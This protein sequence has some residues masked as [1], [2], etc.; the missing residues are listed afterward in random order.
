MVMLSP[1]I[2]PH[3]HEVVRDAD[4]AATFAEL[5]EHRG[6]R[7]RLAEP[8]LDVAVEAQ[9]VHVVVAGGLLL[10]ARGCYLGPRHLL[11]KPHRAMPNDR[12]KTARCTGRPMSSDS[13][14]PAITGCRHVALHLRREH[15]CG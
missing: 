2:Q 1:S 5:P 14:D 13:P 15:S 9:P 8:A 3:I 12:E 6:E 10:R 4:R 11:C 7:L